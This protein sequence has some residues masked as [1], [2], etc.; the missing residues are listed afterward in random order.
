MLNAG[1]WDKKKALIRRRE[2]SGGGWEK[3]TPEV[4][5]T[6]GRAIIGGQAGI[7]EFGDILRL[8]SEEKPRERRYGKLSE[9]GP[10]GIVDPRLCE[11]ARSIL[12]R[13]NQ[14]YFMA[15]KDPDMMPLLQLAQK[16]KVS[17]IGLAALAES[18]LIPTITFDDLEKAP[19]LMSEAALE[20]L[21]LQ[22][23]NAMSGTLAAPRI[24]IQ[25]V[26]LD[27]LEH[28]RLLVRI[29]GP[30]LK[31][32]KSDVYYTRDSVESLIAKI[33]DRIGVRA[34]PQA[35]RL[36]LALR[37]LNVRHVPWGAIVAGIVDGRLE[38]FSLKSDG[39]L[40][41][42]LAVDDLKALSGLVESDALG[43]PAIGSEW[44]GNARAAE[45]LGTNEQVVWRL[46]R[47]GKLKRHA[48]APIYAPFARSEVVRLARDIIFIPEV[49]LVGKFGTYRSASS[50]LRQQNL[51][52]L[53]ELK[54]GGWKIYSRSP[55]E[56]ALRHR[57]VPQKNRVDW[58]RPRPKG[59]LHGPESS[60][61]RLASARELSDS[62]R[63]GFATAAAL[64]G[65]TIFA[66][67][68]LAAIGK[69]EMKSKVTPYS[70]LQVEA[71]AKEIIFVPEIMR[72]AGL[73]SH[74]GTMRWLERE[75][76]KPILFLKGGDMLPVFERQS[77]ERLLG[78]PIEIG[79]THPR[80]VREKL[81]ALVAGGTSVHAAS[82]T[83]TVP[84][85]TAKAWVR[86]IRVKNRAS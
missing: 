10:L 19:V 37:T 35:V 8:K 60:E 29:D 65:C 84:Y 13:A 34:R 53:L 2:K 16:Y 3:I 38:V 42:R 80:E 32:L 31:L 4:L 22:A 70:R 52:E 76:I 12:Q 49:T 5:A 21:V 85:P 81:L 50:W 11:A 71:L 44:V 73:V 40:A 59:L 66:T 47:I 48:V 62:F 43:S 67:Q 41:E 51:T 75:G 25:R 69:L 30:A 78:E 14:A 26:H 36:R 82:K 23:K 83:V 68:K 64:L 58:Q 61:G 45:I 28:R 7:E 39:P 9:L 18:R 46:M 54:K 77:L 27:E 63:I 72:R 33:S 74:R 24:G 1:E 57:V 86:K 55:V 56:R 15:R 20:P 6:A 17:R 79:N